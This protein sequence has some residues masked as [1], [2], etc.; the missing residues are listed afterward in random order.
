MAQRVILKAKAFSQEVYR[1]SFSPFSDGQLTTSGTGH[2]RFWKMASTFTGLKLQGEIGKFGQLELSDVY[3]FA[4]LPDGK[5]VCGTEYGSLLLWEGNLVK[6][7]LVRDIDTKETLHKGFIEVVIL[8]GDQMITAGED[9][10]IRY[11]SFTEIDNAEADEIPEVAIAPIKETFIK[12]E[13]GSPSYITNMMKGN[14]FWLLQDARGRLWKLMIEDDEYHEIIHYHSGKIMDLAVSTQTN[15]AI[16][17]GVD[18]S[19]KL[20]DYL[21]LKECYVR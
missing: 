6:A 4:E 13:N 2:I 5:V 21:N 8:H 16:T 3:G 1:T 14:D 20:W 7:H 17:V 12:L 9:G 18:G 15:A 19:V 10:Y 11:W